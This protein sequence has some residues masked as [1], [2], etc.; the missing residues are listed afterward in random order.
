MVDNKV[1][2]MSRSEV[3]RK[4]HAWPK[5]FDMALKRTASIA[6]ELGSPWVPGISSVF[7]RG[8]MRLG[9]LSMP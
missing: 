9:L 3:V 7:S 6:Y 4:L 8:M 2:V 5:D 1:M